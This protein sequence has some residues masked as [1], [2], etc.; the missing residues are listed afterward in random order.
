MA[1]NPV[2]C[3]ELPDSFGAVSRASGP[4]FTFCSLGLNFDDTKGI[5]SRFHVLRF[6]TLFWW[7]R[8]RLVPF[9][10]F[11]LPDSFWAVPR[12]PILVLMFCVI[13]PV[14]GGTEGAE[15]SFHLLRSQTRLGQYRGRQVLFSYF[16]LPDP[17]RA[18]PKASVPVF[19]FCTPRF[20]FDGTEDVGSRFVTVSR[21]TVP[22]FM[23]YAPK[24]FYGGTE[25][26]GSN[27]HVL[28]SRTRFRR[29]QGHSVLFSCFALPDSFLTVSRASG[30]F[31]MFCAPGLLWGGTKC[32]GFR[33]HVWRSSTRF[34]RYRGCHVQF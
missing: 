9:S 6:L 32:V 26:V 8:G 11:V 33:F 19:M 15:S 23:F 30:P 27:F 31:L 29:Y 16:A 28:R 17:F 12:A 34:G 25:Y 4:V 10:Y 14:L 3:F 1:L 7:Y 5:G 24:L 13:G 2:F 20:V 22:V 18:V 21:A